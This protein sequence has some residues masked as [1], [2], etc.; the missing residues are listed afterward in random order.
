T[1]RNRE[2]DSDG[3]HAPDGIVG[4]YNEKEGS[5]YTIKEIWSPVQF[6][7]RTISPEF[8]G[9]FRIEN[10]YFYTNLSQCTFKAEWVHFSSPDENLAEE[11]KS[12]EDLKIDL[13]PG[14]KGVIQ[15]RLPDNWQ[16]CDALRIKATDPYGRLLN[17]W[18][19]PVKY[20]E[21]K[22][23]E[24][25]TEK[26]AVKPSLQE[27][28]KE[29]V[30]KANDLQFIFSKTDG[31]IQQ[32]KKGDQL[33]PLSNGPVF[34]SGGKKVVQTTHR[35]EGNALIIETLFDRGD[36]L[37][38][39]V[40]GN[41]LLDLDAAYEPSNNFLFAGITFDY[42]EQKVAGMKW[43]GNGPYRVYKNRMK[44]VEYGL[45]EKAY[46]NT[47]TG[48]SG[49][50]Y[51]EFKGYHSEVYWAKI[52]GKDSPDFKVYIHSKD[53]FLRMLTPAEPKAPA[54]T[55]IEYPKGDISFL[56][57]INAIGTKFS[58]PGSSGPQSMPYQFSADKIHG[59]KITM[60]LTFDFR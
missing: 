45:W 7:K 37:K 59:R 27:T 9:S 36:M 13:A 8:N 17:T 25:L 3:N 12:S 22:A 21:Q 32:I 38:W 5:F 1:D 14:Q 10:R 49:F 56:H 11:L 33:I 60:K 44:G 52:L 43:L 24:L 55:K 31:T 30:V 58:D 23:S 4:P 50:I 54:K 35:F 57:G 51:P 34:V 2:L 39:T 46:N 18:S 47:I 15:L 48:E 26:S 19:W 6:E 40:Q 29:L 41:G 53:I 20:P 16:Q 42:P 28:E